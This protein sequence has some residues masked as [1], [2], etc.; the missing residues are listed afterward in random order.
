MTQSIFAAAAKTPLNASIANA[1]RFRGK[2]HLVDLTDNQMDMVAGGNLTNG[3]GT[4]V[5]FGNQQA[6]NNQNNN[7]PN[8]QNQS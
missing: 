8:W 5:K 6:Q 2:T 7:A 4:T 1:K 3:G